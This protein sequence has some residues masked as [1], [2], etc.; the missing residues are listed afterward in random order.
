MRLMAAVPEAERLALR[1]SLEEIF[2]IGGV[3][4][5]RDSGGRRLELAFEIERAGRVP[6]EPALLPI[7][8]R[9][10]LAGEADVVASRLQQVGVDRKLGWENAVVA[11]RLFEQPRVAAGEKCGPRR[12]ALGQRREAIV[13]QHAVARDLVEM[14]R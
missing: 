5:G 3:V 14:R 11:T 2:K 13:E 7:A 10:A 1:T 6:L 12:R 4:D 9:P 8:G